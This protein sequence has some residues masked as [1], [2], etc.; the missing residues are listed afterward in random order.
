MTSCQMLVNHV[1]VPEQTSIWTVRLPNFKKLVKFITNKCT[2]QI[3][4]TEIFNRLIQKV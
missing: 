3:N 1:Y 2:V 4:I